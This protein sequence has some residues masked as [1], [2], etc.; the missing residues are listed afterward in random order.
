[1][2]P[3]WLKMAEGGAL[4]TLDPINERFGS[5]RFGYYFLPLHGYTVTRLHG[6]A[7]TRLHGYIVFFGFSVRRFH[8]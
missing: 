5:V 2:R 4:A 3:G 6:Y 8:F 1:M 7:V